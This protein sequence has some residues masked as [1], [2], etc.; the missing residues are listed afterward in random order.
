MLQPTQS[1]HSQ[2]KGGNTRKNG[3]T[4]VQEDKRTTKKGEPHKELQVFK[5]P[6]VMGRILNKKKGEDLLKGSLA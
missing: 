3:K 4:H 6:P 5:P 2:K 1:K